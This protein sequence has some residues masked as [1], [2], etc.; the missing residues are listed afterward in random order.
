[1]RPNGIAFFISFIGG[2]DFLNEI[3]PAFDEKKLR[4]KNEVQHQLTVN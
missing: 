4:F 1:M 2:L 3:F